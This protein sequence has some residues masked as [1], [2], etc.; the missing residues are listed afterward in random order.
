MMRASSRKEQFETPKRVCAIA[1]AASEMLVPEDCLS[2]YGLVWS[3]PVLVLHVSPV[4]YTWVLRSVWYSTTSI[5][6]TR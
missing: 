2:C 5:S 4:V 3:V 1:T 6:T